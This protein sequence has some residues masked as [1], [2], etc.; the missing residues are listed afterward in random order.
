[1]HSFLNNFCLNSLHSILSGQRMS[2]VKR[3][4]LICATVFVGFLPTTASE[5]IV[6]GTGDGIEMLSAVG[7]VFSKEH[8]GE[9]VTIP[10]S[11]GSGGAIAAVDGGRAVLGRIARPLSNPEIEQG[12]KSQP[13]VKIPSA[14]FVH[15]GA[16]VAALTS[17][18]VA[19][20]FAGKIE[21]WQEVGGK[22]LKI[23][24]VR[25]EDADSTLNVLRSTL[26]SWKDLA[27]TPKSKLAVTTQ[28]AVETVRTVEGAIGFGPYS[29]SLAS[30]VAVLSID[31]KN[32]TDLDYPSAVSLSFVYKETTVTRDAK[33]FM[34][35]SSTVEAR[36]ILTGMGGVPIANP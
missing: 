16:G 15:K 4:I 30:E 6:P 17:V 21:N 25:R 1:M 9:T 28:E 5:L 33:A 26:Q 23:K 34:A 22:N 13:V 14:I 27:I 36:T 8:P 12:L 11:T 31:D 35:F 29:K 32:P 19:D 24:I 3:F 10:A 20:I 7:A 2:M 18:Q